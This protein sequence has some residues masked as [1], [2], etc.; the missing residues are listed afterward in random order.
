MHNSE[1]GPSE[2]WELRDAGLIDQP[3]ALLASAEVFIT[4]SPP[5]SSPCLV[6]SEQLIGHDCVYVPAS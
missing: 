4:T 1:E 5:T 2:E 6:N 3:H